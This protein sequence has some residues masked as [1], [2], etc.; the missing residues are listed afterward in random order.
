VIVAWTYPIASPPG[1]RRRIQLRHS[2]RPSG[3]R[4]A[5]CRAYR[6]RSSSRPGGAP[7]VKAYS[8]APLSTGTI[9]AASA[10]VTGTRRSRAEDSRPV[11]IAS[12]EQMSSNRAVLASHM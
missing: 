8:A 2:W 7:P 11:V 4:P 10:T 12:P 9:S 5:A 1:S 6:A 3:E